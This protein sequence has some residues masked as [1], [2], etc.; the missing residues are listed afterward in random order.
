MVAAPRHT[1]TERVR[2]A[3]LDEWATDNL[4]AYLEEQRQATGHVP[5][6]ET[7]VVERF[8]DELGDW[9]IAIHPLR[10]AGAR[11]VGARGRGADA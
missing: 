4:L 11:P 8:R 3:G 7:I 1:A 6:D 9:R 5:D 10:G 2:E